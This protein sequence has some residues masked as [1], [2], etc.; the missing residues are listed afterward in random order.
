MIAVRLEKN[1]LGER[2]EGDYLFHMASIYA[3]N[4]TTCSAMHSS[5]FWPDFLHA[6][7]CYRDD[8]LK[9]ARKSPLCRA[10]NAD[11]VVWVNIERALE[12]LVP[13]DTAVVSDSHGANDTMAAHRSLAHAHGQDPTL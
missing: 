11:E 1:R 7:T 10:V 2:K 12:A 4:I 3:S 6:V 8:Y 9:D 5:P 13:S